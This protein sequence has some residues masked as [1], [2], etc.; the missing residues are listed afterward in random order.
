MRGL[1]SKRVSLISRHA[2]PSRPESHS[3]VPTI[4]IGTFLETRVSKCMSSRI[5]RWQTRQQPPGHHLLLNVVAVRPVVNR[6][7]GLD[8]NEKHQCKYIDCPSCHEYVNGETHR[9]FI[10]IVPKPQAN[11]KRKR[12][13]GTPDTVPEEEVPP[14]HVFFDIEAMQPQ[15]RH[16]AN[17]VVA[18]TEDDDQPVCFPGH[19]CVRDFLEWLDTLTLNDTRQ[20]NV[21]AHNFQGYDGLFCHSSI[22]WRQPDRSTTPERV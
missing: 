22:L 14:L 20:V 1:S 19:H 4:V 16:I 17:L 6:T 13:R 18:E 12:K 3:T 10:Q 21:L 9:C 8:Q 5:R 7:V 2:Y 11:Q 15:E